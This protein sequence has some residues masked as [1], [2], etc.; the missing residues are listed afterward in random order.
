MSGATDLPLWSY[1]TSPLYRGGL[2]FRPAMDKELTDWFEYFAIFQLENS[3]EIYQ[4]GEF[5]RFS[6]IEK[7]DYLISNNPILFNHEM[8]KA[9]IVNNKMGYIPSWAGMCHGSAPSVI[10][11]AEPQRA[12]S[13]VNF[14]GKKIVFSI[15]DIKRLLSY[16]WGG[17]T[18]PSAMVGKRCQLNKSDGQR[19]SDCTDPNPSDFHLALLNYIGRYKKSFILDISNGAEVWNHPVESFSFTYMNVNSKNMTQNLS[20]ALVARENVMNDLHKEDRNSNTVAILGIIMKITIIVSATSDEDVA[21]H[22]RTVEYRYD[23]EINKDEE[24]IGGQWEN[25]Y[26]PDFFWTISQESKPDSQQDIMLDGTALWN[27]NSPPNERVLQLSRQAQ[28]NGQLMN[29]LMTSL[30]NLSLEKQ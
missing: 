24:I 14:E 27:G 19:Q 16:I 8:Q 20:R 21:R 25:D 12:V 7:Y 11:V 22:T 2:A 26:H 28:K 9:I 15:A 17:N 30:L 13:V 29:Y 10:A 1:T 18:G 5:N 6:P 3:Y 4:S 23:L